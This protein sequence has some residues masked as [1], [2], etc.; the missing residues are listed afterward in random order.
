MNRPRGAPLGDLAARRALGVVAPS[1]PRPRDPTRPPTPTPSLVREPAHTPAYPSDLE[2]PG[3]RRVRFPLAAAIDGYLGLAA[4]AVIDVIV[5]GLVELRELTGPF[6]I[7]LAARALT[8]LALVVALPCGALAGL[9]VDAALRVV[10]PGAHGAARARPLAW[11]IGC[12]GVALAVEVAAARVVPSEAE[13]PRIVLAV[14]AALAAA[15]AGRALASMDARGGSGILGL[16][17][18]TPTLARG[19]L[20]LTVFAVAAAVSTAEIERLARLDNV[21]R[22]YGERAAALGPVAALAARLGSSPAGVAAPAARASAQKPSL[23][24]H[25]ARA[26]DLTGRDIV[27]VTVDALRADHVGAYGYKRPTTPHLDELAS[28]SVVFDAAYAPTSEEGYGVLSLMAGKYMRP[29]ALQGVTSDGETWAALL[30]RYGYATSAFYPPELLPEGDPR[31]TR[32]RESGLGFGS[33]RV[34]RAPAVA[35]A[36]EIGAA[37]DRVPTGVRAFVWAH[38]DEPHEPYDAPPGAPTF[39]DRDIDRYDAAIAVADAGIGAIVAEVRRRRPEAVIVV[40]ADHGEEFGEHGGRYHGAS[41]F[42]EQVRVPLVVNAPG[43][44]T[45]RHVAAP[46]GLVDVL[47]TVLAALD[48]PRPARVRGADLGPLLAGT[49][50]DHQA[51]FAFAETDR[52]TLVAEGA[53][54]L[55][56]ARA[57]GGCALYDVSSDPEE[58]VDVSAARPVDVG[59]LRAELRALEASHGRYEKAG[60]GAGENGWPDALRRGLAG[61]GDAAEEVSQLLDDADVVIRR[62][63]AEVLFE[64]AR[65]ETAAALRRALTHEEDDEAKR[66]CALALTRMGEG[67]PRARD[68][69]HDPELG[70]RR[71][72]ALALAEAGDDRGEETLVAWWRRA[73]PTDKHADPA[74]P[75]ELER[76]RQIAAALGRIKS[77]NAVPTLIAGLADERVRIDVARALA[78]IGEEVARPSLADRLKRERLATTR[79]EL[80]RALVKL[81]GGPELRDPLVRWLGVPDPMTDG[82]ALA[83]QAKIVDLIGGPRERELRRLKAFAKSGVAIGVVVP[84]GGNGKGVRVICRART[85]DGAAGEVRFGRRAGPPPT[86]SDHDSLVPRSAPD[87]DARSSV[88]LTVPPG[89][90]IEAFA[91]LPAAAKIKAGAYGDFVVYATQNVEVTA[92]ALV[93]LADDLAPTR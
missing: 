58:R 34:V 63:A 29:L 50:P 15:C 18:L 59:A 16:R 91:T 55:V 30:G 5:V 36:A 79:V 42:D 53:E 37:L 69:L 23:A 88:T 22:V 52:E 75:I 2:A 92:C 38:V 46:V 11:A 66:W 49:A 71:L 81:G 33:K 62:K 83:Q 27:L 8:P 87:V 24:A 4:F 57:S 89:A 6:E 26:I 9:V 56:C 31:F 90:P 73:Y 17:A 14:V 12:L 85:T 45:P 86:K 78:L 67:A 19:A 39:G 68:L 40:T 60:Q 84:P 44:L 32:V 7:G 21:R 77:K 20:A 70:W 65:K 51:G 82:L 25:A 43:A 48:V 10:G 13:A 35:R 64:R 61:D 1:A 54:R 47:P 3:V 72:A 93:P 41:V 28:E 74:V 80:A 76:A